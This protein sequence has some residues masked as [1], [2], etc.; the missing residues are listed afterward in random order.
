MATAKRHIAL[1]LAVAAV[2]PAPAAQPGPPGASSCSGCH[3]PTGAGDGIP[4]LEGLDAERIVADMRA[5]R[6]G[7]REATVMDRIARGFTE[8][9]TRAIAEWLASEGERDATGK[10]T[11]GRDAGAPDAEP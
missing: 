11:I 6:S 4:G 1:L 3:A 5:F 9:E 8:E 7:E 10:E 2:S